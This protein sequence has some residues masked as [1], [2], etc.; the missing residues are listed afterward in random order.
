[1]TRGKLIT[2]EGVDGAGKSTH[3]SWIA[4]RLRAAGHK[5]METR[6]PGGTALG[7]KLREIILSEPMNLETECLLVFA[8]RREHL[9]R[10]ILPSLESGR[11]VLSDRFTDASFAYQGGGR[12]LQQE[13]VAELERWTLG[14][15]QP[16]LTLY[17]D[18]PPEVARR[19]LA[20]SQAQL[21]RFEREGIQFFNRV[22]NVYLDRARH[23]PERIRVIDGDAAVSDIKV[24]L[25]V[26][27]SSYCK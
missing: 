25:E 5:V 15:L 4:D 19:R 26:I 16:D 12:G 23:F 20:E 24:Q 8:A 17:F 2:L 1:M 13:K 3:A 11:W 21:D 22:R 9:A 27:I 6:E 10:L 18:V 14:D 7:E